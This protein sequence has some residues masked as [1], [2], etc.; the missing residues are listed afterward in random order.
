MSNHHKAYSIH[1]LKIQAGGNHF[2]I[3]NQLTFP[4]QK[5]SF[6]KTHCQKLCKTA[7]GIGSDGLLVL[8]PHLEKDLS[9]K[10]LFFNPD[11][12]EGTCGNGICCSAWYAHHFLYIPS[13]HTLELGSNRYHVTVTSN[14]TNITFP[15]TVSLPTKQLE[16]EKIHIDIGAKHAIIPLDTHIDLNWNAIKK[17]AQHKLSLLLPPKNFNYTFIKTINSNRIIYAITFEK[18]VYDFTLSCGTGAVSVAIFHNYITQSTQQNKYDII[19]PGGTLTVQLQKTN[20][21]N[22][23]LFS[24]MQLESKVSLIFKG[25]ISLP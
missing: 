23:I 22:T 25:V 7:F 1:F 17:N 13:K 3:V 5:Q 19:M 12:T 18:G 10:I 24:Q 11:G 4:Q 20:L 14:G 9:Y 21:Q 16:T 8:T 15:H 6:W 2:I